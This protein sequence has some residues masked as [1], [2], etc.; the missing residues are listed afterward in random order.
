MIDVQEVADRTY[1]FET[2]VSGIKRTLSAYV[3]HEEKVVLVDPGPASGIP[4]IKE[5][6]KQLQINEVSYIIPT[7]I[8]LDHAGAIGQLAE[9]F[10]SAIVVLH[11][12]AVKHAINPSRLIQGTKLAFGDDFEQIWGP[13][14]PVPES[15]IRAAADGE[16]IFIG[17]RAIKLIHAPGHA[18]H[19]IAILDQKTRGLFS[20]EAIGVPRQGAEFFPLPAV[21]PPFDMEEYLETMKKLSDLNPGIIFYSHNGVGREPA[22]LIAKALENTRVFGDIVL[23]AMK[24]GQSPERIGH[25]LQ[26]YVF[27]QAGVKPEMME[28]PLAVEAYKHYFKK[29]GLI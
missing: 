5:V 26:D 2:P 17:S 4:I 27:T 14:A 29:K 6:I 23:K 10:P 22:G 19:H 9:L 25:A 3:I 15:Q 13:I 21:V 8:H 20:G 12:L 28:I 16:E 7:H 1:R 24:E 18:P 11:P